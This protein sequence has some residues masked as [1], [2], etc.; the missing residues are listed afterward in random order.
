MTR[1]NAMSDDERRTLAERVREACAQAAARGYE[2]AAMAG[3]CSEGALEAAVSAVQSLD[4][5]PF[6]AD[7][8]NSSGKTPQNH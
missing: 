4:L 3:L 7:T 6:L 2:D 5:R 1:K 8:E